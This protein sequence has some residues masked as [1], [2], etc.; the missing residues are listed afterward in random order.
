VKLGLTLREEHRL[1]VLQNRVL[2]RIFGLKRDEV[3][4]CWR[5]LHNEEL[6][7]LY[8]SPHIITMIKSSTRWAGHTA[9]MWGEEEC[10][11]GFGG[12]ASRKDTTWKAKMLRE[13]GWCGMEWIDLALDR[14][15]WKTL[16]NTVL[17][18]QVS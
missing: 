18:L 13:L 4:G 6:H 7:N 5:K 9:C 11:Y 8:S 15:Q 14:D 12:Q 2:K 1:R 10:I 3:P 16:V 17:N